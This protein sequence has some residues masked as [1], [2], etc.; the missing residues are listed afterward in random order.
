ME[1]INKDIPEVID[2]NDYSKTDRKPPVG[3]HYQVL[4]DQELVIFEKEKV[5]GREI[6]KKAD[7]NPPECFSLYLKR[8]GCEPDLISLDELVDLTSSGV[9][10]FFTKPPEIFFYDLD[11]EP[12]TT[13]LK[14]MSPNQILVAG[15]VDPNTHYLVQINGDGSQTSYKDKGDQPIKMKCP[16]VKYIS[17]LNGP[18]PVS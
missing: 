3:K 11:G 2:L 12:E 1:K 15:G 8:K 4:V 7:R 5:S 14:E 6:L 9:E 17:V 18:T 10:I 16:R 13:D